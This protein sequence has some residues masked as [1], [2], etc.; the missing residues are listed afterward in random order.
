MLALAGSGIVGAQD[1]EPRAYSISPT[2]TNIVVVAYSRASGD[3]SFDPTLPIE[4]GHATLHGT[5][6]AYFRSLD[7]LGRSAN[8]TLTLPYMWG[9]AQGR[10]GSAFLRARRS[11]LRDAAVRFGINLYGGPA[12]DLKTFAAYKRRTNIGASIVVVGP[13]GQYDP[14]RIINVGSNRWAVKP[15]LGLSR[16]LGRFLLDVYGGVWLFT[17]NTNFQGGTRSQDPVGVGQT[18][19][20]YN[21]RRRLWVS[22]NANFYAGGRTTLNGTRNADFQRNSRVGGTI[23]IPVSLRQ[24]V[25]VAYSTGAYTT[26]GADFQSVAIAYQYLWGGGL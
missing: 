7:V 14:A 2:G 8:V 16:A 15:E 23:S 25:K 6:L 10:V 9:D 1:L 18:H 24:S 20:S 3:L 21:L 19:I 22:F 17:D 13:T 5:V 26:I 12:M 4:D 11:G